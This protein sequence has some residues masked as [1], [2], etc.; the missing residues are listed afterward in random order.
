MSFPTKSFPS[1]I[2][3]ENWDFSSYQKGC[4]RAFISLG[5][6]YAADCQIKLIY[7]VTVTDVDDQVIYQKAFPDLPGAIVF[8]NH[9]YG[10]WAPSDHTV[11]AHGCNSCHAH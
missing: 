9:S 11:Q 8:L 3:E 6:D 4:S 7:Y 5:G 2:T 1:S 10:H